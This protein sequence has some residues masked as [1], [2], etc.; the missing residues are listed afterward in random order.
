MSLVPAQIS[1]LVAL[2]APILCLDTCTIL[3]VVR[4]ITRETVRLAD[5]KA[6]LD[7]LHAA[8][9]KSGLVVLMADQIGIELAVHL[10][11]VQQEAEDKLAKFHGQAQRIHDVASAFGAIGVMSTAHLHGHVGRARLVLDRWTAAAMRV[12]DNPGVAGR[13]LA[14]VNAPRTPARKGKDS[15][16]DCV[17]VEA[18]LETAQQLRTAGLSAPIVFA[19]SNT[20]EYYAPS[21]THLP[22]DFAADLGMVSMS[23]APNFGAAKFML[24]L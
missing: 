5:A 24:G 16:K 11:E 22:A 2:G 3:D 12:P 13:A 14:R 9:S 23:Y 8:E 4:D 20:K 7:L 1:D 17:I 15:I 10:Q 18:Y 19:S 6:G 21:T